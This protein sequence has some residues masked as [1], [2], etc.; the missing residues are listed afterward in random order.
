MDSSIRTVTSDD[1]DDVYNVCNIVFKNL[2]HYDMNFIKKYVNKNKG[3]VKC[4]DDNIVGFIMYGDIYF[5]NTKLRNYTDSKKFNYT[6]IV[7]FGVLDDHRRRGYGEQL[8]KSAIEK[9]TKDGEQYIILQSLTD[10]TNAVDMYKRNGFV[11]VDTMINYYE[12]LK[13][14]AYLMV[15]KNF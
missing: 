11:I 5:F 3:F 1:V 15:R 10:N 13:K 2:M 4:I 9:I 6:A 12:S 8:L 7:T 14:D